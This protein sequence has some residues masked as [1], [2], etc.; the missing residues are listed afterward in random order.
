M[1]KYG[2]MGLLSYR[3]LSGYEIVETFRNSLIFFWKATTSQVYRELKKLEEDGWAQKTVVSQSSRPDKN[4]F[5]LTEDGKEALQK[6]LQTPPPDANKNPMLMKVFFFAQNP[7]LENLKFFNQ[8][9]QESKQAQQILQVV[10]NIV[11]RYENTG[12]A[13]DAMYWKM[14]LDFGFRY[15]KML[16]E[17]A[18]ACMATI[19]ESLKEEKPDEV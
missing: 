8:V 16:Q 2:I 1:L 7:P 13:Q 19:E 10:P 15:Q 4:V 14:T 12:S 5:H 6:W 18:D 9:A 3:D 17:W 11:D